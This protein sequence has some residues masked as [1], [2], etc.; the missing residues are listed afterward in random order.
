M[1]AFGGWLNNDFLSWYKPLSI[2]F[3]G[4]FGILGL[5][6]TFKE[7]KR[8][9]ETY[10]TVEKITK[11]GWVSMTVIILSTGVGIAAQRAE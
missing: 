5:V 11:W 4:A 6:K 2:F 8:D 10:T 7:K 9:P 1:H 3:T